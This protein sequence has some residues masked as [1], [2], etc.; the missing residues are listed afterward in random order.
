MM[1]QLPEH[2]ARLVDLGA[3]SIP[4][5]DT[6]ATNMTNFRYTVGVRDWSTMDSF[7]ATSTGGASTGMNE[8]IDLD[9]TPPDG[10]RTRRK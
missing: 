2:V 10:T 7:Y 1:Q 6:P 8:R 4:E 3:L 9:R 5:Q